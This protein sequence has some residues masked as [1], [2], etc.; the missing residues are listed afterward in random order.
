MK[1]KLSVVLLMLFVLAGVCLA[2][3]DATSDDMV[4][5]TVKIKLASDAVVKGGGLQIDVKEGVVT[6]GGSVE[7]PNQK[8]RAEKLARKVKGVKQVINNITIRK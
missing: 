7:L 8:E 2:K 5:N 3:Q 1:S 4:Y 6:L